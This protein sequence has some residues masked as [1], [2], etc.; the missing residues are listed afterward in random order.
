MR[1]TRAATLTHAASGGDYDSVS[2]TLPVVI[3][4]K[5]IPIL[6]VSREEMALSEGDTDGRMTFTVRLPH[7]PT[8]DVT[9]TISGH[10]GTDLDLSTT[11]LTFTDSDWST[12]QTVTVTAGQDDDAGN[13][14]ATLT[15]TGAGGEYAGVKAEIAVTVD[16]DET[17]DLVLDKPSLN[18]T[19]GAAAEYSVRLSHVPTENVTVNDLGPGRTPT[20]PCPRP[21]SPSTRPRTG[22]VPRTVTVTAGQDGDAAARHGE[23]GEHRPAAGSTTT[24]R[25]RPR[26]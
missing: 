21:P 7:V 6:V 1:R 24:F 20:C 22:T 17:P 23:A 26:L 9:I 13:D 14:E 10:S 2:K 11:T 3:D 12:E 5:D 18:V 8:Q 4:D 25:G 16:D 19:E 15:L